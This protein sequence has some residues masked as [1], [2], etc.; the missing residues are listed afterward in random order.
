MTSTMYCEVHVEQLNFHRV[1]IKS[2]QLWSFIH[3]EM[4]LLNYNKLDA[5]ITGFRYNYHAL[6]LF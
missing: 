5:T 4:I 2:F 6:T 1:T 3:L